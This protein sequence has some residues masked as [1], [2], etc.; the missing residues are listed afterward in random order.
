MKKIK[1]LALFLILPIV[2]V[3]VESCDF[4]CDSGMCCGVDLSQSYIEV[5]GVDLNSRSESSIPRFDSIDIFAQFEMIETAQRFYKSSFFVNEAHACSPPLPITRDTLQ[6]IRVIA[7]EDYNST[8]LAGDLL[9]DIIMVQVDGDGL[10]KRT[11]NQYLSDE[12]DTV[13]D[14][15]AWIQYIFNFS[16]APSGTIEHSFTVEFVF[17][18]KTITG[19]TETFSVRP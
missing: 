19:T 16:E 5:D 6:E 9:N 14:N 1:V 2:V 4:F 10:G 13:V 11:L 18:D 12:L 3:I 8:Y 17:E 7:N 15:F